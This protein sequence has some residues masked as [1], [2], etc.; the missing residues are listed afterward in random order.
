VTVQTDNNY[1]EQEQGFSWTTI[2]EQSGSTGATR[3]MPAN[4]GGST[5][6]GANAPSLQQ[7][8]CARQF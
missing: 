8:G 4:P 7:R 3:G 5:T 2:I 6:D 1:T